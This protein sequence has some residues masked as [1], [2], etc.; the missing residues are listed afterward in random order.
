MPPNDGQNEF[1]DA[2]KILAKLMSDALNEGAIVRTLGTKV[3]GEKGISKFERLLVA[4]GYPHAARDIAYLRKVQELRS[5]VAAHLKGSD[6]QAMLTR[7]LGTDRGIE[8]VR[9]L[10]R[11]GL[12][13]LCELTEWVA[14]EQDAVAPDPGEEADDD[15]ANA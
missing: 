14:A 13:F 7:N 10:L 5:K 12:T 4:E 9:V 6:Y 11:E 2:I 1:E 3:A 8:A 15:S